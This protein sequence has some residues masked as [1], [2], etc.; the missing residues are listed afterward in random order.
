ML[1]EDKTNSGPIGDGEYEIKD[2]DCLESIAARCGHI[3]QTIWNHPRNAT[4]KS[5]RACKN[6]LLPGD[7]L[8]I[9]PLE[10]GESDCATDARHTF[11]LKGRPCKV[12]LCV[13]EGGNPQANQPYQL[14]VDNK[15]F[16]GNTDSGGNIEATIP[17]DAVEGCLTIG[18]GRAT[19]RVYHLQLGGMDPVSSVSG[20]QK[21]LRNLGY[22]CPLSGEMDDATAAALAWFQSDEGLEAT[23]K[24]DDS[25]RQKL[26]EVHAS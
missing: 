13:K 4:L 25:T 10:P 15:L 12:R 19:R 2:G 23:G 5:G 18:R 26:Q 8:H 24:P 6:V 1:E 14:R 11:V 21:R 16:S 17:P 20:V 3:W 9:P 7:R 22:H